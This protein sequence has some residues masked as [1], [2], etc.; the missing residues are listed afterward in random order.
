MSAA[1]LEADLSSPA[2]YPTI[3]ASALGPDSAAEA[4]FAMPIAVLVD[5]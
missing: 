3:P 4:T 5:G 2:D 1:R